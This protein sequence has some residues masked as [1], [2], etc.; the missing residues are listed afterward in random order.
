MTTFSLC[1][2]FLSTVSKLSM[3]SMLC[4]ELFRILPGVISSDLYTSVSLVSL[5]MVGWVYNTLLPVD[6]GDAVAGPFVLPSL[7]CMSTFLFAVVNGFLE[8]LF[9]LLTGL[10]ASFVFIFFLF[11]FISTIAPL[12]RPPFLWLCCGSFIWVLPTSF[13]LV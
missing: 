2:L 7:V 9:V 6:R 1:L 10:Y 5:S 4:F 12:L 13:V 3:L 11:F 8:L